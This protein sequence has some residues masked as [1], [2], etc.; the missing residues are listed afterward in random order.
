MIKLLYFH[1]YPQSCLTPERLSTEASTEYFH[2]RPRGSQIGAHVSNHQSA[3]IPNSQVNRYST[4]LDLPTF[5]R[6]LFLKIVRLI[7]ISLS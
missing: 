5:L 2:S 7:F 4:S 6:I 3:P 1:F